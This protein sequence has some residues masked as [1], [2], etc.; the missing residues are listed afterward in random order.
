VITECSH[1]VSDHG[2]WQHLFVRFARLKG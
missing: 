2:R 1:P